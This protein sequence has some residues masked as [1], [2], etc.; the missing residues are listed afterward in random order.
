MEKNKPKYLWMK[1][2]NNSNH[3]LAF[4]FR[5]LKKAKLMLK[6]YPSTGIIHIVQVNSN[7]PIKVVYQKKLD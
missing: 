4:N 3:Q 5:K 7:K 6:T 1:N 2:L